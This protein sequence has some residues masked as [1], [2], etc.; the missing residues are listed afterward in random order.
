MA[1]NDQIGKFSATQVAPIK[2]IKCSKPEHYI[3]ASACESMVQIGIF[4]DGTGNN[5]DLDKGKLAHSNVARLYEVYLNSPEK[6]CHAI[7]VAGLGTPFPPIGEDSPSTLGSAFAK[8]GDSRI[9]YAL[10]QV[11]NALHRTLFAT[12]MF[13]GKLTKVL[14][15]QTTPSK[16]EEN[17]LQ[18]IGLMHGLVGEDNNVRRTHFLNICAESI[19]NRM[20]AGA[21]PKICE[22]SLD[23]FGF[24]RG[25]AEARVFCH[26]FA[27][28]LHGKEFAGI[29]CRFR[30]LGLMD[31]VASV[32]IWDGV[33]NSVSRDT[34]GHSN[35]A[36]PSSLRILTE[37]E[38][39]VHCVA[40]HELRKN[41][42][43]DSVVVE[44]VVPANCT[45]V[46]YPGSHSDVGG[47]YAPGELGVAV[48][49]DLSSDS[50]KLSQ[51]PLNHMY[52]CAITA[53]VPLSKDRLLRGSES[54]AVHENL[55]IAYA[56]FL[57]ISTEVPR[58]LREWLLPYLTWRWQVK[59]IY[60]KTMQFSKANSE[61]RKYL[62]ESNALFCF[63][64][65]QM[66]L[67]EVQRTKKLFNNYDVVQTNLTGLELEASQLRALVASQRKIS[68][69]LATFFDTFVHDS[70]AG[71]RKQLAEPTSYWR[72]RRVFYGADITYTG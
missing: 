7:Y 20:H 58:P 18:N 31:T 57:E 65:E 28:L 27:E 61:D 5:L 49:F 71:F 35:W 62:W 14:C 40:M 63:L 19:R 25:A 29:R 10:L 15:Q 52:D 44:N 32:G 59:S 70:L 56:K 11:F 50:L 38:N 30:F 64:D 54:F 51:I 24:S 6:H 48:G 68:P 66:R 26:W 47:G 22:F 46:A 45:E 72:Y 67:S 55:K 16:A 23:V 21:T 60:D 36:S 13:S 3:D 69:A 4:F 34:G 43:L 53:G 42:P 8:G 1:M 17:L 9:T 2:N 39:C 12:V 37:V 41:F 33:K